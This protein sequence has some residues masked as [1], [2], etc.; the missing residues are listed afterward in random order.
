LYRTP[1]A[2]RQCEG[3]WADNWAFVGVIDTD[4]FLSAELRELRGKDFQQVL[5]FAD[6]FTIGV[7]AVP[8]PAAIWLFG[9]GLI[10]LTAIARRKQTEKT[11]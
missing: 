9:S 11:L 10:G 7:T 6:D 5:L 8:V 4:G 2:C 1:A 3:E